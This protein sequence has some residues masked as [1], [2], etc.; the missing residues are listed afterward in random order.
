MKLLSSSC[1]LLVV[2]IGFSVQQCTIEEFE[3]ITAVDTLQSTEATDASQ[4]FMINRTIYNCL[5]TSQTISVYN[6]MSVSIL[7]IRSD[8]PNQLREVRYNM[9]CS[10]GNWSHVGQQSTA[11][12][13]DDTRRNCSDCTDQTV[14]DYHCTRESVA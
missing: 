7:Y 3:D 9:L 10:N 5:S 13:S 6:S 1:L 4:T 11:L 2:L 8:T 12:V 14:N